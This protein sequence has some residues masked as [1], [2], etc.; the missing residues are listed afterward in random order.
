VGL[1]KR[2]GQPP[3]RALQVDRRVARPHRVILVGE[4]RAEEG[5]DAVTHDRV[6]RTLV[7][8][9]GLHHPL[10]HGVKERAGILGIP[11]RQELHGALEVG[12]ENRDLLALA[13]D[14][15]LRGEDLLGEVPR[16]VALGRCEAGRRRRLH[17]SGRERSPAAVTEL[18]AGL[19][20]GA[21]DGADSGKRRAALSAESCAV[22]VR[23]L[24][25]GTR[26][27]R[28]GSPPP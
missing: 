7:A 11:V 9:D 19:H 10:E 28:G 5:H 25:P 6:H 15:G 16:G 17:R 1:P 24:A 23:G 14:R 26:H 20:L 12:E 8:M 4:R 2:V 21:T 18:A 3:H 27:G 13:F 22:A